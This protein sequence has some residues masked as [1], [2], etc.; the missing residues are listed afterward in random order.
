MTDYRESFKS[1]LEN[2][3]ISR[4]GGDEYIIRETLSFLE[5]VLSFMPDKLFRYRRI[6]D[7]TIPSFKN[8]TISLCKANCFSDKYDSMIFI[9]AEKQAKEM[10][11]AFK[12][13]IK[14]V[15]RNIK[16]KNPWLRTEKASQVCYLLEQGMTEKDVVDKVVKEQYFDYLEEIKR[17][18]RQREWRFRDSQRSARIACFTECVQSKYMWDTYADGYHGFALEYDLKEYLI[19]CMN[20]DRPT[21]I[22]PVIYTDQRPDMTIDEANYSVFTKAQEEGW[23][24]LLRPLLPFLDVNMLSPHKPY[25]YKD[26]EEYAHEKEWRMLYYSEINFDDYVEIPDDGCLKS[27]YYGMDIT[28]EDYQRL[29]KIALDKGIKE[30]K[31][32]IDRHTPKYSLVINEL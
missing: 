19:S 25:L 4:K 21:Y 5:K 32:S 7:Y 14:M 10:E 24:H 1:L 17:D 31:V 29:H 3:F 6:N 30:Y 8:G 16:E 27:I 2:T 13:G 15:I 28:E 22:F 20:Q 23:L 11:V 12:D 9:D 18:L 26:K